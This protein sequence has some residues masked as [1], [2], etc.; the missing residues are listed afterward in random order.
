MKRNI[1]NSSCAAGA[2]VQIGQLWTTLQLCVFI[3][4]MP[5]QPNSM[6]LF[7]PFLSFW[8]MP[9]FKCHIC[10]RWFK[11]LHDCTIGHESRCRQCQRKN[12]HNHPIQPQNSPQNDIKPIFHPT[13]T[14]HSHLSVEKR[15]AIVAFHR[16]GIPKPTIMKYLA[17]SFPTVNHW[18]KHYNKNFN[19]THTTYT[20]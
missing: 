4:C 5:V 6:S 8:S 12:R 14:I 13:L 2:D 19:V 17:C 7:Y 18:I 15:A 3:C 9:T 10:S 16:I 1:V 11:Q 20:Q